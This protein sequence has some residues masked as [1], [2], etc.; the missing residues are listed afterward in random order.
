MLIWLMNNAATIVLSAALAA[1]V[2]FIVRGIIR[3][4]IKTC[5]CGSCSACS[6]SD[7][8]SGCAACPFGGSCGAHGKKPV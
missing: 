5:D 6:A 4:R 3:G 7:N 1:S 8:A 2:F